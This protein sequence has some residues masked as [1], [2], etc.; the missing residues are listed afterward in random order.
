MIGSHAIAP[1]HCHHRSIATSA[2]NTFPKINSLTAFLPCKKRNTPSKARK[3]CSERVDLGK[4]VAYCHY[5]V[6][7][8]KAENAGT[9][10][11]QARKL[12]AAKAKAANTS[13][14]TRLGCKTCNMHVC[15]RHWDGHGRID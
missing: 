5:C 4:G 15:E 9:T 11:A 8:A 13:A 14:S 10:V 1:K 3:K 2:A 7:E 12:A 6:E